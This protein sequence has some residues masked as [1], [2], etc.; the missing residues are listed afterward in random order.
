MDLTKLSKI[1]DGKASLTINGTRQVGQRNRLADTFHRANN[2]DRDS[3]VLKQKISDSEHRLALYKTQIETLTK[4][5]KFMSKRLKDSIDQGIEYQNMAEQFKTEKDKVEVQL[6]ALAEEVESLRNNP[7]NLSIEYN[8]EDGK[9]KLNGVESDAKYEDFTAIVNVLSLV[10]PNLQVKLTAEAIESTADKVKDSLNG[11]WGQ[12][13]LTQF[14]NCVKEYPQA[15]SAD[16]YQQIEKLSGVYGAPNTNA[17]VKKLA[18][19]SVDKQTVCNQILQTVSDACSRLKVNDASSAWKNLANNLE[20]F[21]L[22]GNLS[23]LSSINENDF[24]PAIA[25]IVKT[26][27]RQGYLPDGMYD[28]EGQ[29]AK[30]ELREA[31]VQVPSFALLADSIL[32]LDKFKSKLQ[33]LGIM[34]SVWSKIPGTPTRFRISD[35][36]NKA[37][38]TKPSV[39]KEGKIYVIYQ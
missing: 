11:T 27:K 6:K 10:Y 19:E 24:P 25:R 23:V 18:D 31:G 1:M 33:E 36:I 34:D 29:E 39:L 13:A 30:K 37:G 26:L 16:L 17:L 5:V 3:A 20:E 32:N 8:T 14:V 15:P 22:T 7:Q 2:I 21:I 9:M 28:E 4:R 38:F 35:S 12:E